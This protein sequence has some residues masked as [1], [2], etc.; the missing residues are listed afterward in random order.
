MTPD[1]RTISL[2]SN[3]ELTVNIRAASRGRNY[4]AAQYNV[5]QLKYEYNFNE[6]II[7]LAD[8]CYWPNSIGFRGQH[9]K[10]EIGVPKGKVIVYTPENSH[11]FNEAELNDCF[12]SSK[13]HRFIYV[14]DDRDRVI[15]S[16][17]DNVIDI[18]E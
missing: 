11:E 13:G 3:E 18:D 8:Y 7:N 15:I 10:I 6:N 9:V 2:D 4:I 14:D 1:I 12:D 16:D 5:E 17:G